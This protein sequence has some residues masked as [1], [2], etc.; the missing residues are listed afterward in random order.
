MKKYLVVMI[1][2]AFVALGC[3]KKQPEAKDDVTVTRSNEGKTPPTP[4]PP[5]PPPPLPR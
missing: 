3:G 4:P 2:G 1:L 5:P